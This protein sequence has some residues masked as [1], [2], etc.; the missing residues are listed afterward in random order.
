MEIVLASASPR[1]RELLKRLVNEFKVIPARGE[2]RLNCSLTPEQAVIALAENKCEEVFAANAD[3]TVIGCDTVVVFNGEILGKPKD[4]KDAENT[5]KKLSGKTHKVITGV[6]VKSGAKTL[7]ASETTQVTFNRLS[8]GFIKNY[9]AGGSPMDKAG[10]YGIQDKGV[11][12]VYEGSYTNVVG[13]P[14]ELLTRLLKE[15]DE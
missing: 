5:L 13:L 6:C 14:L 4:C 2:E 7:C 8:D 1:R 11:V 12:K 9:V 10:S 15:V 3:K